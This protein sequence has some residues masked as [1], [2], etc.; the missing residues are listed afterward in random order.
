M[1]VVVAGVTGSG[2]TTIGRLVAERLGV[3]FADGDDFHDAA[4]IER[5]RAGRPLTEDDRR[6]WLARCNGRLRLWH[7]GGTGGVLACSALTDR[8]RQLLTAGLP[9]VRIVLL[10]AD[11]ALIRSRIEAR[12]D[13]FAGP[14]LL[15]SQ[16]AT[17][18]WPD[19]AVVVSVAG[20]PET[21]A[22]QAVEALVP[23]GTEP[24]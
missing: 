19:D 7:D 9:D 18:E 23:G 15:D 24:G 16:L 8:S 20:T 11:P 22:A 5:M 13:H 17:L 3:P 1:I 2:K 12:K 14:E 4:A 10:T 21:S 6:P